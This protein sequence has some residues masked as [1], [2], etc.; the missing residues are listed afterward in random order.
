MLRD[1]DVGRYVGRKL[2]DFMRRQGDERPYPG[3]AWV[4]EVLKRCEFKSVIS[5]HANVRHLCIVL[6]HPEL[7]Y[8][9]QNAVA[10]TSTEAL[11]LS[12]R[13]SVEP[14][15]PLWDFKELQNQVVM[16]L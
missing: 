1:A 13:R 10:V 6:I 5:G 2:A 15:L 8:T 9:L 11:A 4:R 16:S 14:Q 3:V 12:R 7:G